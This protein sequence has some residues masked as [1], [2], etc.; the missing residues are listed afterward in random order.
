M[1]RLISRKTIKNTLRLL[2]INFN[3]VLISNLIFVFGTTILAQDSSNKNKSD[4]NLKSSS[5]INPSTLAMEFTIPLGIYGGRNGNNTPISLTYSSKIWNAG[6]LDTYRSDT[7]S[8]GNRSIKN[9]SLA[10]F[11]YSSGSYAGWTSSLQPPTIIEFG[12]VYLQRVDAGFNPIEDE[13]YEGEIL[14]DIESWIDNTGSVGDPGCPQRGYCRPLYL[15]QRTYCE[16]CATGGGSGY[17]EYVV[18]CSG[19]GGGANPIPGATPR[20][21]PN[22]M[23]VQFVKRVRV[24]MPDG[25]VVEFRKDDK[26]Y[27][28]RTGNCASDL[29]GSYLAVNGSRMRLE[30]NEPQ[31]DGKKRDILYLPDGSRY[32]LPLPITP[33]SPSTDPNDQLT[34]FIDAN[35]NKMRYDPIQNVWTDSLDR[36]IANPFSLPIEGMAY[37]SSENSAFVN[38]PGL[39]GQSRQAQLV[40]KKLKTE[41][42][43]ADTSG[44]CGESLLEDPAQELKYIG[45][46]NCSGW[47]SNV[48]LPALFLGSDNTTVNGNVNTQTKN[49]VCGNYINSPA[50]S[51]AATRFNPIVLAKVILPDG[52]NY[53]FK[54]N[55]YGEITKLKFPTGA[56]ERFRY[57][58]IP[59]IGFEM[60]NEFKKA[61]RG[62]VE[63]WIYSDA[64][65]LV[66]HWNYEPNFTQG[67]YTVKITSSDGSISER[68]IKRS[69]SGRLG[70]TNPLDGVTIE[71]KIHSAPIPTQN[72]QTRLVSRK[73]TE[74]T[75]D[76]QLSGGY[77]GAKRDARPLRTIF[78]SYEGDKIL[79]TMSE[80]D[81]ESPGVNG[82]TAPDDRSYFARLNPR[83]VKSY[84]FLVLTSAEAAE[85]YDSAIINLKNKFYQQGQV[86]SISQTDYLYNENYKAR[87]ISSLPIE[88]R[89][90][91][92]A[93]P[94]DV[95]AVTK[96]S[97]DEYGVE[98]SGTLPADFTNTWIDPAT[99]ASIPADSR[100]L[101]GN[102]TTVKV[103]D[104][105]NNAWIETH[106]KYDQY[107]NVRKVWEVNE[108]VSSN[109]FVETEYSTDYA[110]AYPTRVVMPA[111]DPSNTNGTNQGSQVMTTYDF[112]TGLPL[113]VTNDFG[114]T[115][116]TE[117]NDSLL[118]PTRTYAVNFTAPETQSVYD[119]TNLKVTIR[120]QIEAN[121]WDEAT[122]WFDGI[123]RTIKTRAKDSQGDVVTETRYD[124]FGRV[125]MTSN[126]YRVD[127]GGN[128]LT[129]ETVYWS[130]PRYDE[131]NRVVETYAPAIDGQQGASLG[132]TSYSISTVPDYIGAVVTTTDASGRK[133]RSITNGLG[134]LVRVD[135]PLGVTASA[136]L[137][138]ID[139]PLQPTFY[140]YNAQG[141]M[142]EVTQGGQKRYFKYDSLGRL[143]RVRQPEQD[144]NPALN[145]TDSYNTTGQWTAAFSYD[146]LGNVLTATDSKGTVV[147]YTYDK[148]SRVTN[149]TYSVPNTTDPAK[150]TAATAPVEYFYDGLGLS[151][152]AAPREGTVNTQFAKGKLTKVTSSVS[153]TRYTQFDY[154][155]RLLQSEQRTPLEGET[156]ASATPRVSSYKYNFSG[157]LI[158]EMYPSNRVV[159]NAFES[160]GDLSRIYGKVSPNAVERT[161]ANSFSY[162]PDG[163][164]EK[165]RLGNNRWEWAKFNER[166]Q[167]TELNLGAGVQDASLWK[168]KYEYGELSADGTNVDAAKNTGNIARMTTSFNGLAQ[169]FVQTF[170]Y[171]SL[172][173]LTEAKEKSGANENWKESFSYDRYGNRTGF[174]KYLNAIQQSL[175]NKTHPS[176]N[177]QTN[178]FNTGQG[179]SYDFNGNLISDA[180]NRQFTF[181]GDNK[182]SEIKINNSTIGKYFYDGEG[183]RVKK[184][185]NLETTVFVY[186]GM[187]KLVAEYSTATPPPNPTTS[188]TATDQLGS[189]R[190]MTDSQGNVISRRDFMPFGEELTPDQNYRT[191]NLKYN[192]GDGIRQKFTGYQKDEET[193]LDFAE[194]R[195]YENRHARFTAVD[196]LLAS[197][198]SANPQTFNRYVY[199]M[200]NPLVLTDPTGLQAGSHVGKVYYK[201][202]NGQWAF[203]NLPGKGYN[204]RYVG[205]ERNV[206]GQDG[207]SY[208]VSRNGWTQG[209][210]V[211]ATQQYFGNSEGATKAKTTDNINRPL[212]KNLGDRSPGLH[213]TMLALEALA[214]A[215]VLGPIGT[216]GASVAAMGSPYVGSALGS[217]ITQSVIAGLAGGG[218]GMVVSSNHS[219]GGGGSG[220]ELSRRLTDIYS[221]YPSNSAGC[222]CASREALSAFKDAGMD[223]EIIQV[224]NGY[225]YIIDSQGNTIGDQGFHQAVRVGD[226]VYDALTHEAGMSNGATWNEYIQ[227]FQ[228]P[229]LIRQTPVR[230]FIPPEQ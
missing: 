225:N 215:P 1:R 28:C 59:P 48:Y 187:G 62:V 41:G 188:Y 14:G 115:T 116:A 25:A 198:K 135:E 53:E 164:I 134:Q 210:R 73:L 67:T 81:Y 142:V 85:N 50:Q 113:T 146:V 131:L 152:S 178:R 192:L 78:I 45:S 34:I 129:G 2:V 124:N 86:A 155:G 196:P 39:T 183:K 160:D 174:E 70:F 211:A 153:E 52:K 106:T 121:N 141:K 11:S 75:Q 33:N 21:P 201:I 120:K 154:L 20:V 40:W 150:I 171:D 205:K 104:S 143:I 230:E 180:E 145:L 197:G 206:V 13:I 212:L 179:Y 71:E 138:P 69:G 147:S 88:T 190:V 44:S 166:L 32:L 156:I 54:Y 8:A 112:T 177:P 191:A 29:D 95:I 49:N 94:T 42:C 30:H 51:S 66:Q 223:G 6:L 189:P 221:Q 89:I 37:P 57:E 159:E 22:E 87:G 91:N 56:I 182:Q 137:G 93:N 168:L 118:R 151:G 203:S 98:S 126:P 125:A 207:Y 224:G 5:V 157:A 64:Q 100:V 186:D 176:I 38:L 165:L 17:C 184:V 144:D 101:R 172:Y 4:Q 61:N 23:L 35:G 219:G 228:A 208:T 105:D 109:R 72:N 46:E 43:E 99:D 169:P 133:G 102:P 213:N 7:T 108:P 139:A 195:M 80:T 24:K 92:P 119:D 55:I 84:H 9:F 209:G 173:R 3:I 140:K 15:S 68:T 227:L 82:N 229:E 170:R 96:T 90:L 63:R 193:G 10:S 122:T 27:T 216:G 12:D 217:P 162:T 65:T 218:I 127:A 149:R 128:L 202:Y 76:P 199:V 204:N 220:D 60:V 107:G 79:A 222:E 77:A 111:P 214:F 132:I 26:I 163:R 161:Y 83:Q 175:D 158:K 16:E 185:T 19:G 103:L 97:Y 136:D 130:K 226:R 31:P 200:N 18:R 123:G 47:T 181:D 194:A 117:Y 167:V 36:P 110:F 74:W 148:A 58:A 114:Q